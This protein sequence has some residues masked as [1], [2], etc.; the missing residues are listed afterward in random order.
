MRLSVRE[1]LQLSQRSVWAAGVPRGV[2]GDIAEAIWWTEAY[3]GSGLEALHGLLEDPREFDADAPTIERQESMLSVVD[4]G[5]QPG[6]IVGEGVLDLSCA[7]A[8]RHGLG[9]TYAKTGGCDRSHRTVGHLANRAARRGYPSVVMYTDETGG[10]TTVFGTPD[11]PRPL[12][13]ETGLDHAS[14]SYRGLVGTIGAD[15]EWDTDAPLAQVAFGRRDDSGRFGPTDARTL[16]RLFAGSIESIGTPATQ[17]PGIIVVCVDPYHPRHADAVGGVLKRFIE[18]R[19][20]GGDID[21]VFDPETIRD[22][23]RR[24]VEEGVEIDRSVWRDIFDASTGILAPP[25]EGSEKGAGFALNE[26]ER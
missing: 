9:I 1:V 16:D 25:F 4:G 17:S 11:D 12:L 18:D 14:D 7:R 23:I 13:A 26:L 10:S 6:I 20:G 3:R 21:T 19:A 22:R 24:L 8:D 15:L 5:G 2:A